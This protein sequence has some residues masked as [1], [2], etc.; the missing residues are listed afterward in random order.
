VVFASLLHG[1]VECSKQ[2]VL[3]WSSLTGCLADSPSLKAAGAP[4]EG[5]PVSIRKPNRPGHQHLSL[6]NKL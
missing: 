3:A 2:P 1:S 4:G 5:L 6:L